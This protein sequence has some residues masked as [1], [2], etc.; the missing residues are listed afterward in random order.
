MEQVH[1]QF[2]IEGKLL[3]TLP[4]R[5]GILETNAIISNYKFL[6]DNL[7]SDKIVCVDLYQLQSLQSE[8]Q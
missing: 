3:V 4:A 7:A 6:I 8:N 1:G 5:V 2:L